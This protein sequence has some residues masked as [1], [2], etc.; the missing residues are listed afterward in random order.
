MRDHTQK[1]LKVSLCIQAFSPCGTQLQKSY[2]WPTISVVQDF[3]DNQQ[4]EVVAVLMMNGLNIW[5]VP[6]YLTQHLVRSWR[7]EHRNC[8]LVLAVTH[9]AELV[10][11]WAT[12]IFLD[13]PGKLFCYHIKLFTQLAEGIQAAV[14]LEGSSIREMTAKFIFSIFSSSSWKICT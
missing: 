3:L 6:L 12:G 11:C 2:G 5:S 9:A 7:N 10:S 4:T 14:S 1:P 13:F 8:R